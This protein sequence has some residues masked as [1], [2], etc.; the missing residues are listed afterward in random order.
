MSVLDEALKIA[1]RGKPVFPCNARDKSPLIDKGFKAASKDNAE[2]RRWFKQWPQAMIGLPTGQVSGI[3]VV[4]FDLLDK[5]TG[6]VTELADAL[7]ELEKAIGAS[8]PATLTARTPSGGVHFYFTMPNVSIGNRANILKRKSGAK[9]DVRGDGGYV[10]VPP[11]VT[12]DGRT[13]AWLD[14]KAPIAAAP[15][16]L[17]ALIRKQKPE[18][19]TP[20]SGVGAQAAAKVRPPAN[21]D[22]RV[23]KYGDAALEKELRD[24]ANASPG[25]R[26]HALNRAS[27]AL[28][29]LVAGDALDETT[30]RAAL[31][32]TAL[33]IGLESGEVR[34][35]IDSGFAAGL[36]QPRDLKDIG[37]AVAGG[38]VTDLRAER[39]KR[40]KKQ[41]APK[42][43]W[44]AWS[45]NADA[46]GALLES[47]NAKF[48]VVKIAAKTRVMV[49]E[50]HHQFDCLVPEFMTVGHFK[51]FY[52]RREYRRIPHDKTEKWIGEG[53]YWLLH[54]DRRTFSNVVY[55]PPGRGVPPTRDDTY[56][57]WQGFAIAPRADVFPQRYLDHLF[58]SVCSNNEREY[59]YLVDWLAF[60]IQN[61]GLAA[62]ICVVLRSGQGTGKGWVTRYLAPI[63]GPHFR[64]VTNAKHLTGHFNVHLMTCSLLYAD[65]AFFAGDRSHDGVLKALITEPTIPIE[66]KGLDLIHAANCLGVIMSSNNRWVIP[67]EHDDRRYFM[68]TVSEKN[69]QN[70]DYFGK[71]KAEMDAGGPAGLLHFLL[72]RDISDFNI[73]ERPVTAGLMLQKALSMRG[74]DA[75]VARLCED[76][77]LPAAHDK[78]PHVAITTGEGKQTGFHVEVKRMVTDRQLAQMTSLAIANELREE[79]GT[80]AWRQKGING[81]EF[82]PLG[83][84]REKFEAKYG[85]RQW[86][87]PN[88]WVHENEAD[89]VQPTTRPKVGEA[90]CADESE[91]E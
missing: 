29:Q 10:C 53:A 15:A 77:I 39:E 42:A 3:V 88:V 51:E 61:S 27:F 79:W 20:A 4:D 7:K 76:G 23:R 54:Q 13:Y 49:L 74:V 25:E 91:R 87:Q 30:V 59:N 86:S 21:R 55:Q 38:N 22:A 8:L 75:L 63:F 40:E 35:T 82:P 68:P 26:N 2:I 1:A 17:I 14:A 9:I 46:D 33:N 60:K 41:V 81:I 66:A 58:E 65:E 16:A 37:L 43:E 12:A 72:H 44:P 18:G 24:L 85:P 11:S 83:E 90:R 89:P 57:L 84:L 32:T 48:A 52:S 73:R 34:K 31:E 78:K 64:Q 50:R 67:V 80:K 62:E 56:N 69:K 36:A 70:G 47:Y 5:R 19:G 45:S 6:E 28:A 71:L